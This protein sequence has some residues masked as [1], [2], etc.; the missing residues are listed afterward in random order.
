[1]VE[2]ANILAATTK[3][4]KNVRQKFCVLRRRT[5][6]CCRK[7]RTTTKTHEIYDDRICAFCCSGEYKLGK[8]MCIVVA[9]FKSSTGRVSTERSV[10]R[11]QL[12]SCAGVML[13]DTA[14]PPIG[15]AVV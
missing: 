13:T 12:T 3:C 1:M 7:A 15:Y 10:N 6:P 5:Q 4:A 9:I 8:E 2:Y 11:V 14:R